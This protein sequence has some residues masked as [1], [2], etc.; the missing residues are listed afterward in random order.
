MARKR[1]TMK[2]LLTEAVRAIAPERR[3]V[4]VGDRKWLRSLLAS[5]Y[6]PHQ[7]KPVLEDAGWNVTEEEIAALAPRPRKPKQRAD[8]AH[9][10]STTNVAVAGSSAAATSARADSD[11]V[12]SDRASSKSV[13]GNSRLPMPGGFAV[14]PD[15]D[16]L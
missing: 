10:L 5:G 15:S 6:L 13:A 3:V 4:T 11:S 2:T 9:T 8:D 1:S 7:L 14:Q 12:K 16:D